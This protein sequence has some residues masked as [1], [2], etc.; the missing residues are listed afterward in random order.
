MTSQQRSGSQGTTAAETFS[1]PGPFP[2]ASA[3]SGVSATSS[4]TTFDPFSDDPPQSS[5][6]GLPPV[7]STADFPGHGHAATAASSQ[8]TVDSQPY[9][10]SDDDDDDDDDDNAGNG[11]GGG[12][13]SY[14]RR[15]SDPRLQAMY[16][17][18]AAAATPTSTSSWSSSSSSRRRKAGPQPLGKPPQGMLL[19]RSS[20]RSLLVKDWRPCFVAFTAPPPPRSLPAPRAPE[21]SPS[22]ATSQLPQTGTTANAEKTTLLVFRSEADHE[23]YLNLG[24]S[25]YRDAE[26]ARLV[27]KSVDVSYF[28]KCTP[29]KVKRYEGYAAVSRRNSKVKM[30]QQQYQQ[31]AYVAPHSGE[32]PHFSFEELS[33]YGPIPV[34]KFA[35]TDSG[36]SN[37]VRG[38]AMGQLGESQVGNGRLLEELRGYLNDII[39]NGR[40]ARCSSRPAVPSPFD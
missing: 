22:A 2:A 24:S 16:G 20:A 29:I 10:W 21:A 14:P 12:D 9:E 39:R 31:G 34:L 17:D 6:N 28:H 40:Y 30:Q 4:I 35:T 1:T 11:D 15:F 36:D 3:T 5:G 18:A 19:V 32:L 27:K 23:A 13:G 25:P 26:R 38:T 8:Y 7:G 33:D 37:G